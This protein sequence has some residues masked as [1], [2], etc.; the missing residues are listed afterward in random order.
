MRIF[1]K[2]AFRFIVDKGSDGNTLLVRARR[3]GDIER[4]CPNAK[5]R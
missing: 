1:L 3:T 5:A 4:V 2:D